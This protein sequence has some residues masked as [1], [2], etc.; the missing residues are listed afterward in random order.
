MRIAMKS[1]LHV[2][3]CGGCQVSYDR[4]AT[5]NAILEGLRAKGLDVTP[6]YDEPTP[7]AIL[8]CGCMTQCLLRDETIP[9][10][11]HRIGPDGYFDSAPRSLEETVSTLYNE[12]TATP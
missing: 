9:P 10:T 5:V 7:V 12:L 2:R 6:E 4:T 11:W 3:Y 8:V 1:T